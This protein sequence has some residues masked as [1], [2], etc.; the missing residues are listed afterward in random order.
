MLQV[1]A[2]AAT[3]TAVIIVFCVQPHH[4]AAFAALLCN[5]HVA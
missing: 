2:A 4:V 1:S 5:T 3:A